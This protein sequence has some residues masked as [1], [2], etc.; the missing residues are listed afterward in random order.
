M[1]F[2]HYH[3]C[4]VL[5]VLAIG[6]NVL[7]TQS[8]AAALVL[9]VDML[10]T[11]LSGD[12]RLFVRDRTVNVHNFLEEIGPAGLALELLGMDVGK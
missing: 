7:P 11:V 6:G 8:A 1:S 3:A 9:A 5:L 4:L 2:Q 10:D 12:H